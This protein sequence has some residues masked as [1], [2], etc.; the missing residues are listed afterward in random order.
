MEKNIL[1]DHFRN[2]EVLRRIKKREEYP[3]N[4]KMKED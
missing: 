2:G 4:N 1:T 3:T